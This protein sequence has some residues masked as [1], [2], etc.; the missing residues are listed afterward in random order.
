MT[1]LI[2][3]ILLKGFGLLN[4]DTMLLGCIVWIGHIIMKYL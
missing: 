1:L 4:F 2:Y 3:L